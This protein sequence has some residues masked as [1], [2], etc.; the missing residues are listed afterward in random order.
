M[1]EEDNR[2]PVFRSWN[3][4]YALVIVVLLVII[5]SLYIFTKQYA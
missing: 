5:V 4:W 2:P 3:Q 1:E